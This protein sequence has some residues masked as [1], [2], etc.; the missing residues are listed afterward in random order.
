MLDYESLRIYNLTVIAKD[1]QRRQSCVTGQR[2]ASA[3]VIIFVEDADDLSPEFERS[4]YKVSIFEDSV[5]GTVIVQLVAKDQDTL[6]AVINYSIEGPGSEYFSV[7]PDTGMVTVSDTTGMNRGIQYLLEAKAWQA[8]DVTKRTSTSLVIKVLATYGN[9]PQ[10]AESSYDVTLSEGS[11]IGTTGVTFHVSDRDTTTQLQFDIIKSA[12]DFPFEL[13][14]T[15]WNTAELRVVA[16]LDYEQ[17]KSYS[18]IIQVSDGEYMSTADV[19]I[20]VLNDNDHNPE[21]DSS[22]PYSFEIDWETNAFVGKV[23]ATDRD[24]EGNLSSITY[25][26]LKPHNK[27]FNI[28]ERGEI[29][30]SAN[31]SQYAW[32]EYQVNV[33]ATDSGLSPRSTT[34]GVQ[35]ILHFSDLKATSD[36]T[37]ALED[38]GKERLAVYFVAGIAG[39]LL[40]VVALLV[41][42][43]V[44]R[45]IKNKRKHLKKDTEA[46]SFDKKCSLKP[47]DTLDSSIDSEFTYE[48]PAAVVIADEQTS[49]NRLD[50]ETLPSRRVTEE[51]VILGDPSFCQPSSVPNNLSAA[52]DSEVDRTDVSSDNNSNI[53]PIQAPVALPL[54]CRDDSAGRYTLQ[55][56]QSPY[57]NRLSFQS[58]L[59]SQS[60]SI[61]DGNHSQDEEISMATFQEKSTS[62]H[63]HMKPIKVDPSRPDVCNVRA[64]EPSGIRTMAALSA[65]EANSSELIAEVPEGFRSANNR[66]TRSEISRTSDY[67]SNTPT[68]EITSASMIN[69]CEDLPTQMRGSRPGLQRNSSYSDNETYSSKPVISSLYLEKTPGL[70]TAG[71]HRS[72]TPCSEVSTESECTST[73]DQH[74]SRPQMTIYF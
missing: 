6:G 17:I 24:E 57:I 3:D 51:D 50:D 52:Y 15:E 39:A 19:Y 44:R 29:T 7:N 70:T 21:F 8:D 10:F 74:S 66:R 16:T 28:N 65:G 35:I 59:H 38:K 20:R 69:Y 49:Q 60:A 55:G 67:E 32:S 43:F 2:N 31:K 45:K 46:S 34:V 27:L 22:K 26:I 72:D 5:E 73:I 68:P 23:K 71:I 14:V 64:T 9:A 1:C 13:V 58:F 36:G 18:I 42:R 54:K 62:L 56:N 48:T 53:P 12:D 61:D 63:S 47:T 4:P 25:S 11:P 40:I 41:T 30:L 33:R 37:G